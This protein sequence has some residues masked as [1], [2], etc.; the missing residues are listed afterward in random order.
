MIAKDDIYN[1]VN[2]KKI[3]D[4]IINRLVLKFM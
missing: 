4:Y 3:S 1:Y 2:H